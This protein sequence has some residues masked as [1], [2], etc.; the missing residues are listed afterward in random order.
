MYDSSQTNPAFLYTSYLS[1]AFDGYNKIMKLYCPIILIVL[2]YK[3]IH[4]NFNNVS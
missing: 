2:L 3:K 1:F 4:N